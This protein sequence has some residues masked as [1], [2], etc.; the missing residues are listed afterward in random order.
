MTQINVQ[1][2]LKEK[3]GVDFRRYLIL[4]ACNPQFAHQALQL[5]PRLGVFLPCNVVLEEKEGGQL[6]ISIMDPMVMA[7]MIHNEKLEELV[8]EVRDRVERI[9]KAVSRRVS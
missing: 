6:E 9:I 3:L 7:A 2:T 1:D 8:G 4:G 5:E